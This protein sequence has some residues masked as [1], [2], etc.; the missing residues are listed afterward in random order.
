[1]VDD[2]ADAVFAVGL[3]VF[4]GFDV[5]LAQD[6]VDEHHGDV[7]FHEFLNAVSEFGF[8]CA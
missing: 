8:V 3:A 7:G 2:G 5:F 4:Q 6:G 1:M